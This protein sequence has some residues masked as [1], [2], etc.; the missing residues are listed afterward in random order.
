MSLHYQAQGVSL[1]ISDN[2]WNGLVDANFTTSNDMHRV[3]SNSLLLIFRRQLLPHEADDDVDVP[4]S[5]IEISMQY[6]L[7]VKDH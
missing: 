4:Q 6:A 3:I 7:H 1:F 2:N 5:N